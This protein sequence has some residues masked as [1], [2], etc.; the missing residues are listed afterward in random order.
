MNDCKAVEK[1]PSPDTTL[2]WAFS[3]WYTA[4]MTTKLRYG[5]AYL[6][7]SIGSVEWCKMPWYQLQYFWSCWGSALWTR[8]MPYLSLLGTKKGNI[9]LKV[10]SNLSDFIALVFNFFFPRQSHFPVLRL[11]TF[12]TKKKLYVN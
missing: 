11:I 10:N 1:F 6:K 12:V 3:T 7:K 2:C 8:P 5:G 4:D 9:N